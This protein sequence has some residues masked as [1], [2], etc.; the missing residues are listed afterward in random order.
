MSDTAKGA[1]VIGIA[2][3]GVAG[4]IVVYLMQ[5]YRNQSQQDNAEKQ[6]DKFDLKTRNRIHSLRG[7]ISILF[8]CGKVL[9]TL[10]IVLNFVGAI[11]LVVSGVNADSGVTVTYGLVAGAAG[12]LFCILAIAV[13]FIY[14]EVSGMRDCQ[15]ETRDAQLKA[16][17][18]NEESMKYLRYMAKQLSDK[19]GK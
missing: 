15:L 5:R 11:V 6:S 13:F 2:L 12:I 9:A 3:I 10:F 1:V 14:E 4:A 16:N 8:E 19:A 17:Q 7:N 18:I